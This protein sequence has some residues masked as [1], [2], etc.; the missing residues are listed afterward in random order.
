MHSL[1]A[2]L[3]G[4]FMGITSFLHGGQAGALANNPNQVVLHAAISSVPSGT[5]DRGKGRGRGFGMGMMLTNIKGTKLADN[6]QLAPHAYLVYPVDG[7]L[8][9]DAQAA[10]S[11]W[12]LSSTSNS[13]GSTT[14]TLTPSNTEQEDHKQTFT[15]QS[16]DKLYFVE[17]NLQDD[18]NGED[19]LW[20][21]DLGIVT[22]A[23]GVIQN[24]LP[25]PSFGPRG[26]V[27]PSPQQ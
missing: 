9:S 8:S 17:L 2:G 24:N 21:D 6:T 15:L 20:F 18:Q 10:M 1:F 16:G 5:M 25:K 23:N 4:F 12:T 14:V 11:G 19:H 3:F 22:D 7:S 27:T 26:Y 13:D